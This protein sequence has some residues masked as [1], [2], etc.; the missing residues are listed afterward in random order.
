[1]S[2]E[3]FMSTNTD[4]FLAHYGVA[5]MRWGKRNSSPM[6]SKN[7]RRVGASVATIAGATAGAAAGAKALGAAS[8]YITSTKLNEKLV[9]KALKDQPAI[10]RTL[11]RKQVSKSLATKA[12]VL[13]SELNSSKNK[14][15][16]IAGSAFVGALLV[17]GATLAT[18]HAVQNRNREKREEKAAKEGP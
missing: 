2:E 15:A 12:N 9:S 7:K 13:V 11:A 16:I 1:M 3:I 10:V 17:G 4:D 14:T 8:K 5:G 18:I 6:S